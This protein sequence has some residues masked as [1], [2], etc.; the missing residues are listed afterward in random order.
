FDIDTPFNELA[1]AVREAILYGTKKEK[2]AFRYLN[3]KGE[4]AIRQ[5]PFEGVLPN[6]ERRYRETESEA[7]REELARY[8]SHSTCPSC[9]G[10]RLKEAARH[11]FIDDR[12]LPELVELPIGEAFAYFS[13][14]V[15]AGHKGE[16]AEKILKEI[17]DRLEFLVNVGLNYLNL[18]RNAETLSG[19]EAQRIRLA[20]QI[21]AGLVGVMYVLDEPSIGLHQRD[22]QRL[23]DTL[24]HLRDLGNTVIVVEHDEDAMRT[25]DYIVDIGTEAGRHGGQVVAAGKIDDILNNP[26]SLTG[27]YL[28]GQQQIA[29]PQERL[30]P[31]GKWLSLHGATGN[32]LKD[33]ALNIPVGL[34]T[35]VT[36]VSGSGKSRSE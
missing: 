1:E 22:N 27:Q 15:L 11:V 33:V 17:R 8:L 18:S 28:S 5:H 7:V 6:M 10:S 24:I 20:S 26:A 14:L 34:L 4:I 21:G 12:S 29:V 36:G 25:A 19:G 23:L 16:I 31:S 3:D 9:H 2:V 35:C 13:A 30:Q 32:N